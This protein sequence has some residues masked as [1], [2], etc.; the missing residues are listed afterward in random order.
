MDSESSASP[1]PSAPPSASSPA[2]PSP[3]NDSP[4]EASDSSTSRRPPSGLRLTPVP[5]DRIV[6]DTRA[7]H[8]FDLDPAKLAELAASMKTDGL[9]NPIRV[10]LD[11]QGWHVVAGCRRVAAARLLGW[12]HI[13]ATFIP[14]DDGPTDSQRLAENLVRAD[15]TPVEEAQ[16]VAAAYDPLTCGIDALAARLNRSA[17]WIEHRLAIHKYPEPVL[18]ALHLGDISIG[19]ADELAQVASPDQL[20]LLLDAA[21]RSGCTRRQAQLWRSTANAAITDPTANHAPAGAIPVAGPPPT[22]V[23]QCFSCERECDVTGMT[24]ATVCPECTQ[25]IRDAKTRLPAPPPGT[26]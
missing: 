14:D 6:D 25:A 23:K 1:K 19:V 10:T 9:I 3:S 15:L 17:Y 16:A 24:Y 21:G 22:V 12:R 5:L 4:M 8:R 13:D 18:K 11:D 7:N 26:R 2:T 20:G